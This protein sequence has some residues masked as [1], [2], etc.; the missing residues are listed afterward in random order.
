MYEY[1]YLEIAVDLGE[2]NH[3]GVLESSI[4]FPK[5]LKRPHLLTLLIILLFL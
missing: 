2:A 1:T 4:G 5:A 3:G